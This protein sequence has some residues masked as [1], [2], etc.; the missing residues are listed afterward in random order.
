MGFFWVSI[1]LDFVRFVVLI[2]REGVQ[3]GGFGTKSLNFGG[4][5]F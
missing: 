4:F 2:R 3:F 5:F 1:L